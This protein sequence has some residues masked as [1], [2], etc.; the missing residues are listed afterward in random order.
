[1]SNG[2]AISAV[3]QGQWLLRIVNEDEFPFVTGDVFNITIYALS[4]NYVPLDERYI[5]NIFLKRGELF[6]WDAPEGDIYSIKNRTHY[7]TFVPDQEI[8]YWNSEGDVHERGDPYYN[9]IG[10]LGENNGLPGWWMGDQ[11]FHLDY[12]G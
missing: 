4:Y 9:Y 7:I 11:V 12:N 10:P 3:S 8:Y 6:D 5:P 1:L 2:L